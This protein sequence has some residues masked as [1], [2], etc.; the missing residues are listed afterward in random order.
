MCRALV[1][2]YVGEV[3]NKAECTRRLEDEYRQDTQF[4]ILGTEGGEYIDATKHG[5]CSRFMNHSCD[6]NCAVEKWMVGGELRLAMIAIR[7][8]GDQEELTFDYQYS[9]AAGNI[10]LPCF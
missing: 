1:I 4:Y 5:N 9:Q 8:I 10:K 6:P 7:D 3:I 2:E